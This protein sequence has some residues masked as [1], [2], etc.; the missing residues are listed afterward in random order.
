MYLNTHSISTQSCTEKKDLVDLILQ[1][2][3]THPL[4]PTRSNTSRT[5]AS[6]HSSSRSSSVGQ[7]ASRNGPSTTNGQGARQR[8]VNRFDE[9][10][11]DIV[12]RFTNAATESSVDPP[13]FTTRNSS[14]NQSE[15]FANASATSTSSNVVSNHS[16]LYLT[17]LQVFYA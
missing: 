17:F 10:V 16:Y 12:T 1:Y 4:P 8:P 7:Q 5:S 2:V 3:Q 6:A 15:S 11:S 13:T 14:S 9:F